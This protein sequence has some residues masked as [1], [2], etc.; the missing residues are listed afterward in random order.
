M[1]FYHLL[2]KFRRNTWKST[3]GP[4][5]LNMLESALIRI[6]P[7][8]PAPLPA[9]QTRQRRG[10]VYPSVVSWNSALVKWYS[11]HVLSVKLSIDSCAS[12]K[13]CR[14]KFPLTSREARQVEMCANWLHKV[15]AI[16]FPKLFNSHENGTLNRLRK[17]VLTV[18]FLFNYGWNLFNTML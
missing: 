9:K 2:A 10:Q 16:I 4:S 7:L 1:L 12:Y 5:Q 8:L 15:C 11:F 18:E 3:C 17:R 13:Y 14:S 6:S